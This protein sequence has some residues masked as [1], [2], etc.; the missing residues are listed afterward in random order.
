MKGFMV[1]ERFYVPFGKN[2]HFV[3]L[4]VLFH[5]GIIKSVLA[6]QHVHT[7]TSCISA[8]LVSWVSSRFFTQVLLLGDTSLDINHELLTL[9]HGFNQDGGTPGPTSSMCTEVGGYHMAT[10]DGKSA[11][12]LSVHVSQSVQ[13]AACIFAKCDVSAV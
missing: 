9:F 2:E 1:N 6:E 11:F 3:V 5:Y 12:I 10:K 7:A 8:C 13:C 4:L